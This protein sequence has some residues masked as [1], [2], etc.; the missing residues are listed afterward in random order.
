V[1]TSNLS[2]KISY[3]EGNKSCVRMIFK[4]I[5]SEGVAKDSGGVTPPI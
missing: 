3:T 5:D 4:G 1:K 2:K